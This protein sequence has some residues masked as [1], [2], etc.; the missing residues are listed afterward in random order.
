MLSSTAQRSYTRRRPWTLSISGQSL[1]LLKEILPLLSFR[2][3]PSV[4][5]VVDG[6]FHNPFLSCSML[7]RR[8]SHYILNLPSPLLYLHPD[9]LR[10]NRKSIP[11]P[12]KERKHKDN[13]VPPQ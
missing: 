9:L 1:D 13:K 2:L 4:G 10:I 12:K 3:A 8:L 6:A 11:T 7:H 5:Q